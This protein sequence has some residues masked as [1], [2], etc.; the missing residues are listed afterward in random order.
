M[1]NMRKVLS[2]VL[3]LVMVLSLSVTAFATE[4]STATVTVKVNGTVV[5]SNASVASNQ[6]VYTYLVATYGN[7][8]GW[9]TFTDWNGNTAKALNSMTVANR[10]YTNCAVDGSTTD[11]VVEA[12]GEVY[13]GY[14]L[15]STVTT[16]GTITGYNYVYVGNSWVYSVTNASG[17]TVDVSSLYM[18][19]YTMSAGDVVIVEYKQ[20]TSEW[21]SSYPLVEDY[22]YC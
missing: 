2:M 8:G 14:G 6:S 1:K 21:T 22:P 11:I 12:W 9:S 13:D 10:T 16:N 4:A 17:A 3:A 15:V 19:Q 20:V 7:E 5:D 18:N